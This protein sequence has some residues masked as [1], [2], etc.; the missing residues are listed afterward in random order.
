MTITL[1]SYK[2]KMLD[3]LNSIYEYSIIKFFT[4]TERKEKLDL[5]LF[6]REI[7]NAIDYAKKLRTYPFGLFQLIKI[8]S[9]IALILQMGAIPLSKLITLIS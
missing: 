6:T 8:G 2:R 5:I 4:T 3:L 1:R 7:E 9:L